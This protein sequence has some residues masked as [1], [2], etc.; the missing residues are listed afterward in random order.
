M[1][2]SLKSIFS[3]HL[4]AFLIGCLILSAIFITMGM[5]YS[6]ESQVIKEL[7][8]PVSGKVQTGNSVPVSVNEQYIL[9][10]Y[11]GRIGVFLYGDTQPVRIVEVYV[12][13][14]PEQDRIKLR[15][16]IIV[17]GKMNLETLISDFSS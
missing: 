3:K 14:L 12:M 17:N 10:E 7:T 6:I 1:K 5:I 11:D 13:F 9:K 15:D 16:G 2:T 8:F 4:G